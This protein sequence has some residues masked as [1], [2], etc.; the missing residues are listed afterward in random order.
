MTD[1]SQDFANLSNQELAQIRTDWAYE[2]TQLS[3]TRTFFALLRTGFAIAGVGTL[4]TS[5]LAR[6]YPEW[7]VAGVASIFILVGFGIIIGALRR[8][9]E[10]SEVLDERSEFR[11]IS[12][13]L[14][15]ALTALLLLATLAVMLL[16]LFG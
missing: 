10:R 11:P 8:Y 16:F 13:R 3:S 6:S 7:V 14:M 5:I 1:K 15:I 9:H 12:M 2:R 4:V